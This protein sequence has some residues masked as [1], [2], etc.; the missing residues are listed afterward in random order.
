MAEPRNRTEPDHLV[1]RLAGAGTTTS[2]AF[3]LSHGI[4]TLFA[5][6]DPPAAVR[7]VSI[8]HDTGL[9]LPNWPSIPAPP[10]DV[11]APIVQQELDSGVYRL[12]VDTATPTCSWLLQLVLNSKTPEQAWRARR[13]STPPPDEIVVRRG[14]PSFRV[15]DT[16]HYRVRWTHNIGRYTLDLRAEDGHRIH[17]GARASA[18]DRREG[19][20]FLGAGEWS[21][22]MS[23]GADWELVL[24]PIVGPLGGGAQGF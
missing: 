3:P 13:P 11:T 6:Y 8:V 12:R 14:N 5:A 9:S 4:Y 17:L 15:A 21:A 2:A 20:I 23:T 24:T 22:E 7:A 16:G 1:I 10:G 18:G 19:A